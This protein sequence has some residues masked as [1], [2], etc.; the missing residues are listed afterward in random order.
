MNV[1]LLVLASWLLLTIA[2]ESEGNSAETTEPSAHSSSSAQAGSGSRPTT[3]TP[4]QTPAA[5]PKP[6]AQPQPTANPMPQPAAQPQ[7]A[8]QPQPAANPEEPFGPDANLYE[9]KTGQFTLDA[10]QERYLCFASTLGEDLVINGYAS[11]VQP[12]VHHMIFSRARDPE[13]DGFA[14]CDVAFRRGWQPLF[15]SGAGSTKLELPMDAGSQLPKGTQVIVQMH[16]LN[17]R[18]V[19]VDG[20]VTINL[21]RSTVAKP[22]PVSSV[23]FGTAAVELPPKETTEVVGNCSVRS[24]VHLIAGFPHMHML[25]Q[26]LRFEVS[27]A[28]G[29][30]KEI[31]KRDPFNF[32]NQRI[33]NMD[34]VVAAGDKVRVTCS[35]MNPMD[36]TVSYG[37]S[38]RNEM[39]YF[40]GFAVDST[41][42][43]GCLEVLPPD[44]FF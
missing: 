5:Q 42:G 37:E 39:C 27:S 28:G 7:R 19:A 29:P 13:P 41:G 1:R 22:R 24:N 17:V 35:F 23:T 30:M 43:G 12:F 44:I 16:L 33:D 36:E 38:T 20:A 10:G 3:S 4:T 31:F 21:R 26:S 40:I 32:D 14:E 18:E 8:A 11:E 34:V 9:W 2:C 6:A 15:I 25:G